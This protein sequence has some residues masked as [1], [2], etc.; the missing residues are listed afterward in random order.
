MKEEKECGKTTASEIKWKAG[1]NLT[2]KKV[3]KKQK[4]K[5]TGKTRTIE[6]E[7]DC[8]SFFKFFK[9]VEAK[10][11]KHDHKEDESCS[12]EEGDEMM[13]HTDFG[14]TLVDEILPY[15][16]EYY[17]GVKKEYGRGEDGDDG[18][19]SDKGSASGSDK[20]SGDDKPKKKG[21]KVEV[22]DPKGGAPPKQEC[23]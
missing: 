2:K 19:D 18:D 14:T 17:L 11:H 6:K 15:H 7:V 8:E 22:K 1:K 23:K 5:K 20:S 16:L 3:E 9:T 12:D 10:E 13:D 4:N 21:K